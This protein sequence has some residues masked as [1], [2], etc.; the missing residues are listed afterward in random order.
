MKSLHELIT[1]AQSKKKTR[2]IV[3]AS[4]EDEYILQAIAKIYNL[5]LLNP[6]L[7]G[8]KTKITEIINRKN[9]K[10][11]L[12]E[13]Y[14]VT[15]EL[16]SAQLSVDFV[17]QGKA[18]MIMKGL[19]PTKIFIK[20]I[21]NKETGI[22][23]TGSLSHIGLFESPYYPKL[24]GLTDAAININP[25]I[26]IKIEIIRNAVNAFHSLGISHPKVALLAPIE[27]IN[28]K[29]KS[30]VDA[31]EIIQIHKKEPIAE[32]CLEGPLAL[33]IAIAAEAAQHKGIQS[34]VA[35]YAD[36][37]VVPEITVGNVLY[38]S[39]TYLGGA[40][41]AGILIGADAPVVLTSRTD[42]EESKLFSIALAYNLSNTY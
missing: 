34:E 37:L 27:K 10:I 19:L 42:S 18:D 15:S 4:A 12:N 30:T 2:N 22:T 25:D 7:V 28:P 6:I 11:P 40:T 23:S 29:M 9:L 36:I 5:G 32:C 24:F 31:A 14:H 20:A 16:E 26:K 17:R 33:D 13:L 35:G 38:K 41:A 21:L 39:L 3:I 8:D 1:L